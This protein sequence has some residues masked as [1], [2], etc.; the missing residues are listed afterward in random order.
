MPLTVGEAVGI[1]ERAFRTKNPNEIERVLR[2]N[3]N[4][5]V[6]ITDS[7]N[8]TEDKINEGYHPVTIRV[9]YF[10]FI[11][12]V[13]KNEKELKDVYCLE[14]EN[15]LSEEN[16]KWRIEK[17]YS[18]NQILPFKTYFLLKNEAGYHPETGLTFEGEGGTTDFEMFCEREKAE[19]FGVGKEQSWE[20]H[21][22]G[23]LNRANRIL[24]I[25]RLFMVD[26]T[27]NVFPNLDDKEIEETINA[28][29]VSIKISTLLHDIGKLRKEWQTNVG[30]KRGRNYIGRTKGI[31]LFT[32]DYEPTISELV[33]KLKERKIEVDENKLIRIENGWRVGQLLI[34]KEN[35][36]YSIYKMPK[37]PP[38][39]RY[40]YP[41]L[42]TFLRGIFGDWRVLDHIAL[43]ASRHHS[44][45]TTGKVDANDFELIEENEKIADFIA[46]LLTKN[47]K[48]F[49]EYNRSELVNL[50]TQCITETNKESLMDEP[51]TPSDDFYFIY[52]IAN[53]VVKFA[54]WEDAGNEI[55]ELPEIVGEEN[56]A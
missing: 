25:Y 54:D 30:W 20:G 38:H 50:I 11:S 33:S 7:E 6:A 24:K 28:L 47:V 14:Q 16:K 55:I 42:K 43:A 22:V 34:L 18:I 40:A 15:I 21:A 4:V 1:F 44:L 41:F 48:E 49:G 5:Q 35:N 12:K 52:T 23:S 39:G 10:V 13:K 36:T 45:E 8:S 26:W 31:F 32:L 53:R 37:L 51:P 19:K 56:G 46:T 17:I 9:P 29:L 27:K 2:E 3:L